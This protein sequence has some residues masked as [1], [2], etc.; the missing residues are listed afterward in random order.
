M[1][2]TRSLV[3]AIGAGAAALLVAFVISAMNDADEQ[4]VIAG[5]A[6]ET[7]MVEPSADIPTSLAG[8][9]F[10]EPNPDFPR[11]RQLAL[12]DTSVGVDLPTSG[13]V[14]LYSEPSEDEQRRVTEAVSTALGLSG[15]VGDVEADKDGGV[16][17][18]DAAV[19]A[20]D[21]LVSTCSGGVCSVSLQAGASAGPK[22]SDGADETA[23]RGWLEPLAHEV[24]GSDVTLDVQASASGTA[25]LVTLRRPIAGEGSPVEDVGSVS[26]EDGHVKGLGF[27][28]PGPV[29]VSEQF[30]LAL[31]E[32]ALNRGNTGRRP[33][34]PTIDRAYAASD[35]PVPVTDLKVAYRAVPVTIN[36]EKRTA[37]LPHF[38]FVGVD[39]QGDAWGLS[40]PAL[41]S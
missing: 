14:Y 1:T 11:E 2:R 3:A 26:V 18:D 10:G 7:S 28:I 19:L 39:R 23:L 13:A 36:G 40:E 8:L 29:V 4:Q 41:P 25:Q 21:D 9:G 34:E 31:I 24:Y 22:V 32:E 6:T 12:T 33:F 16:S 17:S 5:Q 30:E 20:G 27:E 35:E 37:L 38:D 15:E